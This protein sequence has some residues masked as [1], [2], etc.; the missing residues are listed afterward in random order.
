MVCPR[1]E[2]P[3]KEPLKKGDKCPRCGTEAVGFGFFDV[4][5]LFEEK[6]RYQEHGNRHDERTSDLIPS[7]SDK[8]SEF[9]EEPVTSRISRFRERASIKL[10]GEILEQN[11]IIAKRVELV[12]DMLKEFGKTKDARAQY[13]EMEAKTAKQQSE[14]KE[15]VNKTK[16]P[17]EL[18]SFSRS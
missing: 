8:N 15:K 6:S 13:Y 11:K 14:K 9:A 1:K 10:L 5:L 16:L 12:H 17:V 3:A 7:A 2:C 18:S 4:K